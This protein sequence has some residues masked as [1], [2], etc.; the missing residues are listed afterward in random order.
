MRS[1]IAATFG[2]LRLGYYARQLFFA[3][4]LGIGFVWIDTSMKGEIS[5]LN[6]MWALLTTL[7]YPYSRFLYESVADFLLGENTFLV[8]GVLFVAGKLTFM[9]AC[10]FLAILLAPLGL[11]YLYFR[12]R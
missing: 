8:D 7:L 5:W 3:G 11:L 12:N 10:W 4:I 6:S 9:L 1:I 2:G